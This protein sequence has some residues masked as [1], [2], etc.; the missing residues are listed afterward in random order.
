M[1]GGIAG[2]GPI[3]AAELPSFIAPQ[4][5]PAS[6]LMQRV[7][8]QQGL[9]IGLALFVRTSQLILAINTV[10]GDIGKCNTQDSYSVKV[11]SRQVTG[12][13]T[14]GRTKLFYDTACTKIAIDEQI[15]IDTTSQASIPLKGT[16]TVYSKA[17]VKQ[18]ILALN[19]K[20]YTIS[21][22]ETGLAGVGTFTP[23]SGP[24]IQMGLAC[25]IPKSGTSESCI[26]GLA[27]NFPKIGKAIASLTPMTLSRTTIG[28][29]TKVTFTES[30]PPKLV[31]GP[32][33]TLGLVL[34]SANKLVI[35]GPAVQYG[36]DTVDGS[37]A[38][39]IPYPPKP[40]V[41]NVIAAARGG[42]FDLAL[43]DAT[44]HTYTGTV[45]QLPG[46]AKL[47]QISLDQSGSG[48]ITYS[49]GSSAKISHWTLAN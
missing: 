17:G 8:A 7:L 13:V 20:M 1:A 9:G 11:I 12:A 45:K 19:D 5:T 33:S 43:A 36:T 27:Q 30:A 23:V 2:N 35:T 10:L 37:T 24:K 16:A 29:K 6:L 31:T 18:G 46:G 25:R 4:A 3:A 39:F 38:D 47:A 21:P 26:G 22:T 40:T 48:S 49:D 41:W 15:S 28:D 42:R 34:N 44:K 14:K 32:L